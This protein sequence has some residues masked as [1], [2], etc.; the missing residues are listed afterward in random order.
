MNIAVINFSS[1]KNGNCF[2]FSQYIIDILKNKQNNVFFID[3]SDMN[4]AAC[5]K[6]N[7]ECFKT[8]CIYKNDDVYN[9]YRK[10]IQYEQVISIIPIYCG[11]PCSN[12]FLFNERVQGAF[13]TDEEF[14]LFDK[15]K[16]RYIIIG[17]DGFETTKDIIQQNDKTAE[18]R[19]FL[20][21][22]SNDMKEKSIKGNL[23]DYQYYRDMVYS[24]ITS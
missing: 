24:F 21:V 14:A 15:I 22:R 18:K 7:Y 4:T 20:S 16:N 2:G 23:P 19:D 1:R 3:F 8:N 9:A 10:L 6:C 11:L 17:N 12:F 13:I 5:G